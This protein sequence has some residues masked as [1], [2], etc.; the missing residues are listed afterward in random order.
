VKD[1]LT[2]NP[3]PQGERKIKFPLPYGERGR[4]RGRTPR[5][6]TQTPL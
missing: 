5:L 2:F 1:P 3:L 6:L 4:M